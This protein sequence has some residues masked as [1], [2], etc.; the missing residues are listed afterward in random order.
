MKAV[1]LSL[2]TLA[3][4]VSPAVVV[5]CRIRVVEKESGWPVPLV[6]LV[7]VNGIRFVTDNAGVVAMGEPDLMD[8]EV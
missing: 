1:F 4:A 6:Q 8:R 3:A 2:L 7:T 5:P